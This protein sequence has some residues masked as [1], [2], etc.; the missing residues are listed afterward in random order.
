[1]FK[2]TEVPKIIAKYI[3]CNDFNGSPHAERF[4]FVKQA[5]EKTIPCCNERYLLLQNNVML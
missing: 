2:V 5:V 1:M 3:I 4:S